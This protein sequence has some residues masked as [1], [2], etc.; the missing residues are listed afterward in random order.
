MPVDLSCIPARAKRLSP[1]SPRRWLVILLMLMACG[2]FITVYLWPASMPTQT[3]LFWICFLGIPIGGGLMAWCVRWLAYLSTEWLADGWDDAREWDLAQDIHRGQRHLELLAQVVHLPHVIATASLSEQLLLQEGISLPSQVDGASQVIRQA[4]FD[5]VALP[6]QH[7][8]ESQ[9]RSL[10]SDVSLQAALQRLSPHRALSVFLQ[11]DSN[12][13]DMRADRSTLLPLIREMVSLPLT[14]SFIEGDG[15][16]V[17]DTWL[18]HLD[19]VQ[20]RLVIA[21][22]LSEMETDGTGEVAVALLLHSSMPHTSSRSIVAHIHR[23]EQTSRSQGLNAAL[24]QALHWGMAA[25]EDI[26]GIWLTGMGTG[27]EASS[28]FSTADMRFPAAGQPCDIDMKV[29]LTGLASPWLATAVAAGHVA[30]LSSPQLVMS[31]P[32]GE[33]LPW[34]MV[35]RPSA[36]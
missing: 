11:I 13:P 27:N 18:D 22:S 9:L 20:A 33:P 7:R 31:V 12:M 23:P 19:T 30:L 8:A 21:L 28:L 6:M 4:R 5:D 29:G 15:L 25:P 26:K 2:G 24:R 10:L 36:D 17:I 1:P 32:N 34:F 3:P 14:L 35:I 16:A